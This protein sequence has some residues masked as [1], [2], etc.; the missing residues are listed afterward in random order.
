MRI[1]ELVALAEEHAT[2]DIPS[3]TQMLL[4]ELA[5]VAT[6]G[7]VDAARQCCTCKY[8]DC[9]KRTSPCS[10]CSDSNRW[11]WRGDV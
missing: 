5:F 7:N 8:C 11:V 9:N 3:T 6:L 2:Y 1:D 4:K 10:I